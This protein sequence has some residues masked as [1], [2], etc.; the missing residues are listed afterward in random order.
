M[1]ISKTLLT[2]TAA[3]AMTIAFGFV[4]NEAE[5]GPKFQIKLNPHLNQKFVNNQPKLNPQ[6]F[7]NP[8]HNHS[9]KLYI[10]PQPQPN[11]GC[12]QVV[13]GLYGQPLYGYGLQ[14]TSVVNFS[15]AQ[16][17]GLE[18]GDV[19]T[20]ANGRLI[21]NRWDLRQAMTNCGRFINLTVS[22]IRGAGLVHVTYD[23]WTKQVASS[24]GPVYQNPIPV[25]Q[26]GPMLYKKN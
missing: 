1:N 19:I 7:V 26:P 13:L 5:A 15:I 9:P 23:R 4:S 14:V 18:P 2:T 8:N 6:P 3:A 12:H 10:A 24:A 20:Q 17:I 16:Q 22:D 11:P 25:N 21:R